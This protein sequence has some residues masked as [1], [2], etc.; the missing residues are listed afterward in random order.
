[1][2]RSDIKKAVK[3]EELQKLPELKSL[4]VNTLWLAGRDALGATTEVIA[5]QGRKK[6][7]VFNLQR[8]VGHWRITDVELATDASFQEDLDPVSQ[9]TP[10]SQRSVLERR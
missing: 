9:G 5:D 2:I 1:M 4:R 7:L 6:A 8:A 10:G 3:I